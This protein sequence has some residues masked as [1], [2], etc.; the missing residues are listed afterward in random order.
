MLGKVLIRTISDVYAK[1]QKEQASFTR[2]KSMIEE[3]FVLK[4]IVEQ[5]F[6]WNSSLYECFVDY[7]KAFDSVH[8][9]ILWI[10]MEG[11]GIPP[12]LAEMVKAV[13]DGNQCSVPDDTGLTRWFDVKSGLKQG[14]NISGFLFLFLMDCVNTVIRWKLLSKLDNLIFA[15]NISLASGTKAQIQKNVL[16]FSTK[17]KALG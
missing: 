4:N 14:C 13:Y 16:G 8:R 7:K 9:E 2:G 3:V 10:I 15:D 1:L 17:S 5:A 6:N 12:K 11:Y